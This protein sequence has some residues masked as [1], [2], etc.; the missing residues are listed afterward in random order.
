MKLRDRLAGKKVV[1]VMSGGNVDRA[2]LQRVLAAGLELIS[3]TRRAG[4]LSVNVTVTVITT[5]TGWPFSSADVKRHWRT[6][7]IAAWSSSGIAAQDAD[8]FRR[9]RARR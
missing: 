9:C 4:Y 3:T 2:T 6:A 1:C 8:V 7:S 5:G